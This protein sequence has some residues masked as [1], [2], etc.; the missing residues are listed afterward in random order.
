MAVTSLTASSKISRCF[1]AISLAPPAIACHDLAIASRF[2]CWCSMI[3]FTSNDGILS[4]SPKFLNMSVKFCG[5]SAMRTSCRSQAELQPL[6]QRVQGQ[7]GQAADQSAI[8]TDILQIA[9]HGEL[10]AADQHVDVPA[11]HLIGDEAA[12]AAFLALHEVGKDTHHAAVDLGADRRIACEL[13]ADID[14]HGLELAADL[15]VGRPRI[16]LEERAQALPGALGNRRDL[17]P[18]QQV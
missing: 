15:A 13:A 5:V 6:L 7:T 8:E 14:Q 10:D 2:F 4:C 12:D 3:F 17:R 11:L 16:L 1:L 18:R 9:S